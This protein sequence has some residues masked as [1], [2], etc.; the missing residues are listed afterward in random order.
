MKQ[1]SEIEE[2][3]LKEIFNIGVGHA[4]DSFSRM[5]KEPVQLSVPTIKLFYGKQTAAELAA[6]DKVTNSMVIQSFQ[7]TLA[8]DGILLFS[9]DESLELVRLMLGDGTS[10]SEMRELEQ[11]ALTE[12][13][14]I[15]FNSCVSVISDMIGSRFQC[16]MPRYLTGSLHQLVHDS[17]S[18]D[19]CLLLINIDFILERIR[20][21]GYF[22]FLMKVDSVDTFIG[23]IDS[24]L[25]L[26]Q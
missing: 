17:S 11:E 21:H 8:A 7:G 9:G 6:L 24:A 14:N 19:D 16:G 20:I 22:M 26:T 25:G 12:V 3:A 2:D 1:L 10:I 18:E 5:V 13:G 23:A 4:A 15:L